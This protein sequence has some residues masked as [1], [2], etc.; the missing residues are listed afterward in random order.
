ME[1]PIAIF[2]YRVKDLLDEVTKRTSYL[3]KMRG[4]ESIPHML[5]QMSLTSGEDFLF[6]EFLENAVS[7]TYDWLKAFG[8]NLKHTNICCISYQ[9]HKM[10]KNHGLKLT[11]NG[12]EANINKDIKLNTTCSVIKEASAKIDMSRTSNKTWVK[13]MLSKYMSEDITTIVMD[14]YRDSILFLDNET[15]LLKK[16]TVCYR[17]VFYEAYLLPYAGGSDEIY[18]VI[19]Q[20]D[21]VYGQGQIAVGDTLHP[22]GSPETTFYVT[23]VDESIPFTLP[24]W[25]MY[26]NY[27]FNNEV[28]GVDLQIIDGD[29]LGKIEVNAGWG[30]VATVERLIKVNG[31]AVVSYAINTNLEDYGDVVEKRV[32]EMPI[33]LEGDSMSLNLSRLIDDF[34]WVEFGSKHYLKSVE[35][36][37]IVTDVTP[38][39]IVE[40]KTG[41][42]VEYHYDFD[43]LSLF[44]VYQATKDTTSAKWMSVSDLLPSD[45][46]DTV[47][48]VLERTNHFD[49][50]MINS[51]DRNIKEALVNY[52]IYRWF[53]YVNLQEADKF[54]LK[55][56]DNAYKAKIGMESETKPIQR[57]YKLF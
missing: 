29:S 53:E 41:D 34:E 14:V 15:R 6:N 19:N 48:F 31:K 16:I 18:R 54:Y 20:F 33:T 17:D 3:G 1:L 25:G 5:D 8:R 47:T 38:A 32:Y 49:D 56:E 27:I 4:N 12:E 9:D 35:C 37:L 24:M 28:E 39:D 55:F 26:E 42:Y 51:V 52:I 40:I 21:L 13:Q 44:K 45:P 50:N 7:E 36:N 23:S 11:I 46:R 10:I 57:K 2:S 30:S 22:D 43:D